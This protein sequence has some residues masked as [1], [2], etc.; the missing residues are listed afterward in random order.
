MDDIEVK[1]EVFRIAR[2][3]SEHSAVRVYKEIKLH[4][5]DVPQKQLI[6]VLKE[7]KEEV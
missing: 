6:K 4:L 1:A 3:F 5:P 2:N 7:L